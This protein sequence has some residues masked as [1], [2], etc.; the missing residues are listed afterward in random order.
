MFSYSTPI[1]SANFVV[2]IVFTAATNLLGLRGDVCAPRLSRCTRLFERRPLAETIKVSR[3]VA[4]APKV[5]TD[6]IGGHTRLTQHDIG[7]PQLSPPNF[8]TSDPAPTPSHHSR[9]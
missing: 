9:V 6:L 3:Q 7:R 8:L 1:S 5:R 2:F 4:P